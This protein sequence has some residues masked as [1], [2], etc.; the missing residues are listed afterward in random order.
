MRGFCHSVH[1][2]ISPK[3]YQTPIVWPYSVQNPN[4]TSGFMLELGRSPHVN[5]H[6]MMVFKKKVVRLFGSKKRK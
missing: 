2:R 3:L 6:E 5:V 1:S 4:F